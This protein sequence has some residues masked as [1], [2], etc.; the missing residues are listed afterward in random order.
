MIGSESK[1]EPERQYVTQFYNQYKM[2]SMMKLMKRMTETQAITVLVT[3]TQTPGGLNS[4]I[5]HY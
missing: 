5:F 2:L 1:K 4:S 3:S